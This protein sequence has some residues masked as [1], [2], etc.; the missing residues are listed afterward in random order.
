MNF[1]THK[2]N[3]LN[4]LFLDCN[5]LISINLSNFNTQNVK[6]MKQIFENCLSL[7]S[8]NLSNFATVSVTDM[9]NM[10]Y[11]NKN[12]T[13]IDISSSRNYKYD[14]KISFQQ[15]FKGILSSKTIIMNKNFSEHKF[16]KYQLEN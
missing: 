6:D 9:R 5:S 1:D 12:L 11:N 2:V 13:I 8:L 15:S 3:K 14:D 4:S 10:F 16:V 7:K